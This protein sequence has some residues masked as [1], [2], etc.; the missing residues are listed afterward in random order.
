MIDSGPG[1]SAATVQDGVTTRIALLLG[2][3]ASKDA[4]LRLT[5]DLARIIVE[6]VSGQGPTPPP[7]VQ[8]LNFVYSQMI[9]HQGESGRSPL[10]AVNIETLVSALRLLATRETHEVAPFVA[11]WKSGALGFS[12]ASVDWQAAQ[13]LEKAVREVVSG[14]PHLPGRLAEQIRQI[15]SAPPSPRSFRDAETEVLRGIYNELSKLR[16]TDYLRPIAD[17]AQT[18]QGGVDVISL[19]YDLAIET[20]AASHGVAVDRGIDR[21]VPGSPLT[22]RRRTGLI[23]LIKVH[24]SL[25]WELDSTR[26]GEWIARM[27][28]EVIE[29][30][31]DDPRPWIVVGDR[32]KLAT[33]GPTLALLHAAEG[34]LSAADRLIVVGYSFSDAHIN[35]MIQDWLTADE[36]RTVTI[37]DPGWVPAEPRNYS[38]NDE[39]SLQQALAIMAA[40]PVAL[41]PTRVT[42]LPTGAAQ[43]LEKAIQTPPEQLPKA[44]ISVVAHGG[45][46]PTPI[47]ITNQGVDLEEVR[48]MVFARE[49]HQHVMQV[50]RVDGGP[51]QAAPNGLAIAA[52]AAGQRLELVAEDQMEDL[53]ET[54]EVTVVGRS[55]L[56]SRAQ[57]SVTCRLS[58]NIAAG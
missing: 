45:E 23:N 2:A 51:A 37:I 44:A 18:Q 49:P 50:R 10:G 33:S 11:S 17:L 47:H 42:V 5:G 4:G 29:K 36:R 28:L 12:P 9:G 43:S 39:I 54:L 1:G 20:M 40:Q 34:A 52:L 35:G 30:A 57:T 55:A 13:G 46:N 48:I 16:T 53:P 27:R 15:A 6:Q 7:P 21:W 41:G 31:K 8:A 14:S 22:F 38:P 3:G 56:A 32:E 25:D 26:R 24:G 19:N 58:D